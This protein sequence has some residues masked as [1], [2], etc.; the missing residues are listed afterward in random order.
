[1]GSVI[2]RF[3]ECVQKGDSRGDSEFAGIV[4]GYQTEREAIQVF[5][6]DGY[7][8]MDTYG[9]PGTRLARVRRH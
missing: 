2:D 5:P 7:T 9:L 8:R 3:G 1:M 6:G 4:H